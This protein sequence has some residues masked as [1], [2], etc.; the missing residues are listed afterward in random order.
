MLKVLWKLGEAPVRGRASADYRPKASALHHGPN[1]APHHVGQGVR[2]APRQGPHALLQSRNT[3]PSR[4]PGEFLHKVFDGSLDQLVL[5]MLESEKTSN[6]ELR[7]LEKMISN[8]RRR[9]K[10]PEAE[11]RAMFSL[12]FAFHSLATFAALSLAVLFLGTLLSRGWVRPIER[13]RSIQ[14]TFIALLVAYALAQAHLL[15]QV[16]LGWLP[17]AGRPAVPSP[18]PGSGAAVDFAQSLPLSNRPPVGAS[19]AQPP[20]KFS[21]EGTQS[22]AASS[23]SVQPTAA[24][25]KFRRAS[26]GS[27]SPGQ[28]AWPCSSCSRSGPAGRSCG[29]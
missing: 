20:M 16:S 25:P 2:F 4:R 1:A 6:E 9:R 21:A 17:A 3:R 29:R 13:L 27:R 14:I 8:A 26:V 10:I 7:Q 18:A 24:A 5:S 11:I 22:S 12:D 28:C 15:P 23:Q 19:D